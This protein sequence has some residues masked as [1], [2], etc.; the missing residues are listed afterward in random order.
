ML[1]L[2]NGEYKEMTLK[3]YLVGGIIGLSVVGIPIGIISYSASERYEKEQL[4]I[5]Y[6][7]KSEECDAR[8]IE[9]KIKSETKGMSYKKFLEVTGM[10]RELPLKYDNYKIW[11]NVYV[12]SEPH[13]SIDKCHQRISNTPN[14]INILINYDEAYKIY[15]KIKPYKLND[16]VDGFP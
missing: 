14:M 15:R 13:F 6:I 7:I 9:N 8:S 4:R 2:Y 1:L 10:K 3:D 5:E 11:A 16:F 12:H